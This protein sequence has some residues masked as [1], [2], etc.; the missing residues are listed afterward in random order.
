MEHRKG[1]NFNNGGKWRDSMPAGPAVAYYWSLSWRVPHSIFW[2]Y[3]FD[4]LSAYL[5]GGR[6]KGKQQERNET[7]V[8]CQTLIEGTNAPGFQELL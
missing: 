3:L 1:Y 4:Q 2:Q 6:K 5:V 8:Q 7:N